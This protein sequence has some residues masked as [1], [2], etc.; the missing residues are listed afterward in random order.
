LILLII[1]MSLQE[2][3]KSLSTK[4][5]VELRQKAR[6]N[7]LNELK[8]TD[9]AKASIEN[10]LGSE[11]YVSRRDRDGNHTTSTMWRYTLSRYWCLNNW[12]DEFKGSVHVGSEKVNLMEM[13]ISNGSFFGQVKAQ[14]S[15]EINAMGY[16]KVMFREYSYTDR[17]T[18]KEVHDVKIL[19]PV[20]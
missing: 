17:R 15:R 14:I 3:S 6:T 7:F 10:M 1:L 12:A 18:K 16:P 2:Q 8:L 4:E 9:E 5:R 11:P 13:L 19:V 20:A